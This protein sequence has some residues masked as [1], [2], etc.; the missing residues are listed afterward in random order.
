[1]IAE[2]TTDDIPTLC[3]LLGE[4]FAHESDFQPDYEKQ[5]LGLRL[6]IEDPHYGKIFVM[7]RDGA[8]VGMVNL[9]HTFSLRHGGRA[10]ILEDMIVRRDYRSRGIATALLAHAIGFANSLNAVQ[11]ILFTD[12]NNTRAIRLYQKMGVMH[13]GASPMRHRL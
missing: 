8:I 9:L 3:E 13:S 6:I 4:L 5:V 11:I 1:M 10:L 12:A 2:A 7:H